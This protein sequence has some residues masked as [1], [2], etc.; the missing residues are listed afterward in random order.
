MENILIVEDETIVAIDLENIINSL[1]F[2]VL[3]IAS[4]SKEAISLSRKLR[5]QLIFMDINLQ[6]EKDGIDTYSSIKNEINT[7]V[8]YLTAYSDDDT[9]NKAIKTNPLAYL[10]KPF[11][12]NEIKATLNLAKFKL[13]NKIQETNPDLL[14]I[15]EEFYYNKI[16]KS[17]YYQNLHI[18]LGKNESKL[19]SLLIRSRGIIVDFKQIEEEIWPDKVVSESALRTLIYRLRTKLNY[20][21][22][23]TVHSLGCTIEKTKI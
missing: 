1:G 3:D 6:D 17:L 22:I 7:E 12:K 13:R 9:I 21:L 11:N 18:S 15:G 10:I 19:L 4:N 16:N 5:P 20:K 8:I 23:K 14:N 2:N